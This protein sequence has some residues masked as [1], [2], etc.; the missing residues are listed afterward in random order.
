[1]YVIKLVELI[2]IFCKIKVLV[3]VIFCEL[4]YT[5][6]ESEIQVHEET[7]FLFLM[8]LIS[9]RSQTKKV[10]WRE[11]IRWWKTDFVAISALAKLALPVLVRYVYKQ[12]F[13]GLILE[14]NFGAL[15]RHIA[16]LFTS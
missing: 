9:T 13:L 6:E 2:M 12:L 10:T 11:K 7:F 8:T 1:M 3:Y 16:I 14:N 4:L 5:S 15:V